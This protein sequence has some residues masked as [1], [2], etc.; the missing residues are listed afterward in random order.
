MGLKEKILSEMVTEVDTSLM[1]EAKLI[2]SDLR[3][4]DLKPEYATMSDSELLDYIIKR[5]KEEKSE[6][7]SNDKP[8]PAKRGYIRS[9]TGKISTGAWGIY[10]PANV[11]W[12]I[13]RRKLSGKLF[14]IKIREITD[15][16]EDNKK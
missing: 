12:G 10:L 6:P 13:T 7:E 8:I 1:I 16:T 4:K 11:R 15:A 14:R 5:L 2:L 9:W 3:R